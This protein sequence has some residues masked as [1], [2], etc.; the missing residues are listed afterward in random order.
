MSSSIQKINNIENIRPELSI[1]ISTYTPTIDPETESLLINRGGQKGARCDACGVSINA[2]MRK[3]LHH[4]NMWFNTC[5]MCYYSENLDEIPH[6]LKGDIIYFPMMSQARLNGF[7]RAVW[8]VSYL[9]DLDPD[10]EELSEMKSSFKEL[11][12]IM[13]GQSDVTV[14]YFQTSNP[15]VISSMLNIIRPEEYK[16]R[17]KL[18][19]SFRWMPH[20][21]TFKEEMGFWAQNDYHHL[22][23]LKITSNIT[24]FVSDYLPTYKICK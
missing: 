9:A 13:S 14:G 6:Y 15:D 23:P 4:K 18:L 8:S 2:D 3:S 12:R 19:T 16:Q 17:H 5:P 24:K 21:E 7:L 22:H 10:N 20:I 1:G 11:G